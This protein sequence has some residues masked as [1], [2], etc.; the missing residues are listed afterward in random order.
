MKDLLDE[1]KITRSDLK[2][3]LITANEEDAFHFK[4]MISDLTYAIDWMRLGYNPGNTRGIERRAAYE[5]EVA[6]DPLHIQSYVSNTTTG[7]TG[8]S[9]DDKQRIQEALE[10]LTDRERDAY[11]MVRGEAL[12]REEV[13]RLLNVSKGTVNNMITRCEQ[14]IISHRIAPAN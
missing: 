13:A 8:T 3:A 10:V 2:K 14:K 7:H 1:Y 11:L 9:E 12:P 4:R 6:V 5:R